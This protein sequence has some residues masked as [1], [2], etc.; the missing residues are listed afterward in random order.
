[1]KYFFPSISVFPASAHRSMEIARKAGYD[2]LEL[3]R[4]KLFN[5]YQSLRDYQTEAARNALELHFHE[6]WDWGNCDLDPVCRV[7]ALWGGLIGHDDT[8]Q[9]QFEEAHELVVAY[10]HHWQEIVSDRQTN[11]CLQTYSTMIGG[12]FRTPFLEFMHVVERHSIGV[13]FDTQH[14]LEYLVGKPGIDHLPTNKDILLR[15]L[16]DGFNALRPNVQ[17]IHL[18]NF[19]PR[20][21]HKDGRNMLLNEGVLPLREFCQHVVASGWSGTIVPEVGP[22]HFSPLSKKKNILVARK[23]LE[24]AQEMF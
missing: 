5:R 15:S 19:D 9:E 13:V 22:S 24:M 14:F 18:N 3:F 1:M 17:E 6:T 4:F 23:I 11:V 16:V 12:Q 2:G 7:P 20:R 21:G 8:L 10:P